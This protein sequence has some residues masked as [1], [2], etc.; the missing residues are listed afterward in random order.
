[1]DEM[2]ELMYASIIPK[3]MFWAY[4]AVRQNNDIYRDK[5]LKDKSESR[6]V[7]FDSL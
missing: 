2:K 6:S 4:E 5:M 3:E 7:V 1:M